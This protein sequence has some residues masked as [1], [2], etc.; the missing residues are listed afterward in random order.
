MSSRNKVGAD[1][2]AFLLV[3]SAGY[4][5]YVNDAM[6]FNESVRISGEG[7]GFVLDLGS[8]IQLTKGVLLNLQAS[9][10]INSMSK[11]E[12]NGSSVNLPDDSAQ[13]NTH[14]NLGAGLAFIFE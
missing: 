13:N 8:D 11:F 2:S 7:I 4:L 1:E 5:S 6:I 14:I 9:G 12:I 3:I 10:L